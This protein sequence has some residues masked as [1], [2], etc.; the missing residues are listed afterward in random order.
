MLNSENMCWIPSYLSVEVA[1][2]V[3]IKEDKNHSNSS[4]AYPL[5]LALIL[6]GKS[7]V[8]TSEV[9]TQ[10]RE[11]TVPLLARDQDFSLSA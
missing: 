8:S 7:R 5:Q 10:K 11:D 6:P 9:M 2:D 3:W 1:G 4:M